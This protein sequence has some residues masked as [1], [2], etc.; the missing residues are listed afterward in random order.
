MAHFAELDVFKKVVRILVVDDK[1][2]Q[3]AE[4]NE[5]EEIGAKYLHEAFGG[6]WIQTSFNKKIRKNSAGIGFTYDEVK[7]AF[8]PP[9]PFPSWVLDAVS[10]LWEAPTTKPDDGESYRWNE[11]TKTWDL[12]E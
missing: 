5:V 8:I 9:K 7:D 2:T 6:T 11:D 10:C 12:K 3:D 1:D 4:G